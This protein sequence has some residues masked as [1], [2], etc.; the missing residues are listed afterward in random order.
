[1]GVTGGAFRHLYEWQKMKN[2]ASYIEICMLTGHTTLI[3]P[4]APPFRE[5]RVSAIISSG[6][7]PHSPR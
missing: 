4:T 1:M 3:L 7:T 6:S 2:V 5:G